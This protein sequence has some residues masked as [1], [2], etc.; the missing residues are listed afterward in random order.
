M[1][2]PDVRSAPP[3][4]EQVRAANRPVLWFSLVLLAALW[5]SVTR[6]PWPLP[7]RA[8]PAGAARRRPG[9]R[10]PG[11]DA[12]RPARWRNGRA[13]R[14]RDGTG[15]DDGAH[16]GD[17]GSDVAGVRGLPRLPGPGADP[18]GRGRLHEPAGGTGTLARARRA[19]LSAREAKLA[20]RS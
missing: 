6:P 17:A 14:R 3:S 20:D 1:P 9:R 4:E 18:P 8:R 19:A 2:S 11:A 15:G 7:P 5:L 12:A 13:R 10:R 16:H